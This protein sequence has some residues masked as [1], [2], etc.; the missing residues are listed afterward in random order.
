MKHVEGL[1]ID[2]WLGFVEGDM[3]TMEV[4]LFRGS[5]CLEIVAKNNQDEESSRFENSGMIQVTQL[6]TNSVKPKRLLCDDQ[7]GRRRARKLMEELWTGG[8][9]TPLDKYVKDVTAV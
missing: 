7:E 4:C 8:D 5:S 2:G 3:T 1:G 9:Y 6:G